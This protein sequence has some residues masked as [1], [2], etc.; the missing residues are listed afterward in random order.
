MECANCGATIRAGA[1]FCVQCGTRVPE[2][3]V[4]P[5]CGNVL[6]QNQ[7]FCAK[8]GTKYVETKR[9]VKNIPQ[10]QPQPPAPSNQKMTN[11]SG[12]PLRT[13]NMITKFYGEPALGVANK[14]GTLSIYTDHVEFTRKAGFSL[15]TT[16]AVQMKG[17]HE[18]YYYSDCVSIK[19]GTYAVVYTTLVLELKNGNKV[20]FCPAIPG[21]KEME[22]VANL[23]AHYF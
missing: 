11:N 18:S 15:I 10:P 4:C 3:R 13:M 20:T 21:N 16:V 2:K 1:Q 6:E 14:I 5:T 17:E 8:C 19:T 22:T 9:S 12:S 23:L 7:I